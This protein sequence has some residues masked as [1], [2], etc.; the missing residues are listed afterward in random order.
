MS[1]WYESELVRFPRAEEVPAENP[2]LRELCDLVHGDF[3]NLPEEGQR[4][5]R[6]VM[7]PG[8]EDNPLLREI[9]LHAFRPAL[10]RRYSW[11]IPDAGALEVI[12]QYSPLVEI[13]AGT[14]YWA[15]LLRR[16]GVDVIA[17]DLHPPAGSDHP[18]HRGAHVWT[19]VVA[20]GTEQAGRDP[21]R[22]LL[23]CW[24]PYDQPMALECLEA[25]CGSTLIYI[26]EPES[27]CTAD[28]AFFE[29]LRQSWTPIDSYPLLQ[30]PGIHDRLEV[31][32]RRG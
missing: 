24:P 26:G 18:Y 27:G 9:A 7:R 32:E 6:Q 31:Y 12:A 20:G 13:G 28:D 2:Y 29:R 19:E 21:E 22:A 4:R 5:V 15:H 16:R 14:G 11:A 17:F 23:L 1:P 10:V 8:E 3:A 30:W 25:Y